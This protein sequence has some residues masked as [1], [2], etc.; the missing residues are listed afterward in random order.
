[1]NFTR[2]SLHYTTNKQ[3]GGIFLFYRAKKKLPFNYFSKERNFNMVC[4]NELS[5]T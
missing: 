3:K 1:M 4:M 2:K 5:P